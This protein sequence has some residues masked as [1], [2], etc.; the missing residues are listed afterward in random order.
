MSVYYCWILPGGDAGAREA[1][2]SIMIG[3]DDVA[4]GCAMPLFNVM[5]K[6][7]RH[8]GAAGKGQYTKMVNQ[9][10][11]ASNM[12]GVVEGLLFARKYVFFRPGV[13]CVF[14]VAVQALLALLLGVPIFCCCCSM[15]A[16][17]GCDHYGDTGSED[18]CHFWCCH[19]SVC[20][21]R[22]LLVVVVVHLSAARVLLVPPNGCSC[23]VTTSGRDWT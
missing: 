13:G 17:F 7:N 20:R 18:W 3:G 16:W 6:N 19:G 11:I 8:M 15:L 10:L 9:I 23:V 12:I 4:V 2:L 1:R 21:S 5:G 22:Q 14:V